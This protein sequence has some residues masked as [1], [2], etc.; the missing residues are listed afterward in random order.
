M[1]FEEEEIPKGAQ[2]AAW[3][4]LERRKALSERI[5]DIV[6]IPWYMAESKFSAHF[7]RHKDYTGFDE[8]VCSLLLAD[9]GCDSTVLRA[10]L[11]LDA[12]LGD[13]VLKA[14]IDP[15]KGTMVEGDATTWHLTERGRIYAREGRKFVRSKCEFSL[16]TDLQ[17]PHVRDAHL[18]RAL[19]GR[20]RPPGP[21]VTNAAA[22]MDSL[23][24]NWAQ[25]GTVMDCAA[26]QA[27]S[28]HDPGKGFYLENPELGGILLSVATLWVG[29][30]E[31]FRMRQH[32]FHAFNP[33]DG[34]EIPAV[35]RILN[36]AKGDKA[37]DR[38]WSALRQAH[39]D[40]IVSEP[41]P[42][43]QQEE[44]KWVL[45]RLE[46]VEK[47]RE[48]ER[49]LA[50]AAIVE[51]RRS[52]DTLEFEQELEWLSR[53]CR[54][55][56][57]LISPWIRMAAWEKRRQQVEQALRKGVHIFLGYSEPHHPGDTMVPHKVRSELLALQGRHSRL[58]V[59]EL[60]QFHEKIMYAEVDGRKYEYTGSF[61]LL[62]FAAGNQEKIGREN[63]RRLRW[64]E[65]STANRQRHLDAF[66]QYYAGK[67]A[68]AFLALG[69]A[70]LGGRKQ[71]LEADA[72]LKEI[73]RDYAPFAKHLGGPAGEMF[74]ARYAAEEDRLQQ[75]LD[76]WHRGQLAAELS[77]IRSLPSL[78]RTATGE[79]LQRILDR[80]RTDRMPESRFET[81]L[82]DLRR[83]LD[84]LAFQSEIEGWERE[85][86]A[87]PASITE[88]EGKGMRQRLDQMP[89]RFPH[90]DRSLLDQALQAARAR[91]EAR[92]PKAGLTVVGKIDLPP[93]SP[94]R[95]KKK[96]P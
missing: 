88:A 79:R 3:E 84:G 91:L 96:H 42:A 14:M 78:P 55:E 64:G 61:N 29:V 93:Q 27:Q 9:S 75:A 33:S 17:D 68:A 21:E 23:R 63:M 48:D 35:T 26:V 62:S 13:K 70:D 10:A 77:E 82:Q 15:L 6:A 90:A 58:F 89:G 85:L 49:K 54:G 69:Q 31:D 19:L 5:V 38:V 39:A 20:W 50:S 41:A 59:A 47:L 53:N 87:K 44:E 1:L 72:R 7:T 51:E 25:G 66:Q 40:K 34:R 71:I 76:E 8:V 45:Q 18:Y 94:T 52:F 30:L 4:W 43:A 2:A 28:Y 32:H 81:E 67:W 46:E 65:D 83:L 12:E 22:I 80:L 57:W 37:R 11:G 16:F 56:W 86:A 95:K 36:A 74:Q 24:G 73:L 60:P 92:V